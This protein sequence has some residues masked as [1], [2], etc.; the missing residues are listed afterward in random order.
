[1]EQKQIE[2]LARFDEIERAID[3]GLISAD[4]QAS[5]P[6][7]GIHGRAFPDYM[8]QSLRDPSNLLEEDPNS[9]LPSD[10]VQGGTL[11]IKFGSDP[12][13]FNFLT[14]N[15]ADVSEIQAYTSI[16]LVAR[17]SQED[18]KWA[19]ELAYYMGEE[20]H[21]EP[22][23]VY[24][25]TSENVTISYIASEA[26]ESSTIAISND[27][28][29]A[30]R[31]FDGGA[32]AS[33][34]GTLIWDGK[35]DAGETLEQGFYTVVI[36]G[37]LADGSE[38]DVS[39]DVDTPVTYTYKLREDFFWH[40][41]VVDWTTGR[42]DWLRGD[43]Q[44]T[45]NDVIF[46]VD[47]TMN[48]QVAGA[49]PLRSY[50]ENLVLWEAPD[51]FSLRVVF[52]KRTYSQLS[53]IRGL[54]PMPEFLYAFD[55][56]GNRNDDTF[57]GA[58]FQDHWY[59]PNALGAGPY[60]FVGFQPGEYIELERDP[61]FPLGGN[62]HERIMI[63]ILRDQNQWARKLRTDEIHLSQLQ[64]A[65]YRSEYLEA[66]EDSPF[67]DGSLEEGEFWEHTYFYIGWNADKPWFGDAKVRNAMSHAFNADRIL[68][69]VFLGLGERCTGPIP[70]FLPY[71]NGELEPI[72]FDLE[73][74]GALLDEAGW[75]MGDDGVREKDGI[76][77]EFSLMIYGSSDEYRIL[78]TIFKE[79]LAQIGVNMTVS[80]IEWAN[81]LKRVEDREY[82]AVTLAWVS[83]PDVDF[84]QI[85][86]SSQADVPGGSNRVGF[87]S[88]EADELIV[89]LQ[90]EFDYSERLR[91]AH[92]FHELVYN[93]QPY[94]FF[95]TRQRK[96]FWQSE[97][98]NVR[99]SRTRPYM[100]PRAWYVAP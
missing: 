81:L 60:R 30:V 43:H 97:L 53:I 23:I 13:G 9:W 58:R 64:P 59:N 95:Y 92:E 16:G 62:A 42:Y 100:N 2:L 27:S 12:K 77:F 7:G 37:L 3:N 87:R 68:N 55:E 98:E 99:F 24:D 35:N 63:Q 57:V 66:G 56:D 19:P 73:R 78:G 40:E 96:V 89:A 65:Q 20:I 31:Q 52:S 22:A 85:W 44:V 83:S 25:G 34:E 51:D 74:A 94:T 8:V 72:P 48:N 5:S 80:P 82:D 41:P 15:G 90:E 1:M 70:T 91:L 6:R 36:S 18:S 54:F 38:A 47:M 4:N 10:A 29:E 21:S 79:D 14:E 76:K 71:Y 33:G 88:D 93:E 61:R 32:L 17:H 26:A 46:M 86:H 39:A 28:G 49:A 84:Y 67:R 69:E 11:N 50:F 45:A 75:V